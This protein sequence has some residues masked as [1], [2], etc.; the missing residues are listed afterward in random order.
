[1]PKYNVKMTWTKCINFG[2][3]TAKNKK[4]A[5]AFAEDELGVNEGLHEED[6]GSPKFDVIITKE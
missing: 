3:I 1:M 5:I 6:V 4:E 2:V